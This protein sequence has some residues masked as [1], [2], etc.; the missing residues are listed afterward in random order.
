MAS[1]ANQSDLRI[2]TSGIT[3]QGSFPMAYPANQSATLLGSPLPTPWT[4]APK[5]DVPQSACSDPELRDLAGKLRRLL[6][7]REEQC[8]ELE[9]WRTG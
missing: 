7:A 8:K 4:T 2:I 5:P 6:G 3:S 9:I 1:P